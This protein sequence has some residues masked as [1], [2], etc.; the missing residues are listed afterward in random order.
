MPYNVLMKRW[1]SLVTF[2]IIAIILYFAGMV[3]ESIILL[4]LGAVIEAAF[5][6]TLFRRGSNAGN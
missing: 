6:V 1:Y 5:W 3:R 4:S 2:L